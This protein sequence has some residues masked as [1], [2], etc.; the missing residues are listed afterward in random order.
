MPCSSMLVMH[1]TCGRCFFSMPAKQIL[2][3][4]LVGLGLGLLAQVLD[5]AGEEAA[6]AA[7]G[8]EDGFAEAGIDLIDDELG[9]RPR[10]VVLAR[11]AGGL[12]VFEQLL[13][14]V[15]EH[16]PVVGGV[17]VDA[18]DLVDDLPHQRAVLHVVVGILE[19]HA[20][21][22]AQSCPRRRSRP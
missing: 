22:A 21:Q 17:E 6:G 11:V 7:G 9:D 2:N 4:P 18:V 3:R 12:E 14:D 15:A 10:R 1:S 16:V 13:V 8:V 19:D 20:D 5:G